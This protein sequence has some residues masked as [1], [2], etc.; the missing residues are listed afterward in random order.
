MTGKLPDNRSKDFL[1]E[2]GLLIKKVAPEQVSSTADFLQAINSCITEAEQKEAQNLII[3]APYDS[4]LFDRRLRL[5]IVKY[6]IPQMKH[7]GVKRVAFV[8]QKEN[9]LQ[10]KLVHQV[11]H[12]LEIGVFTTIPD[13]LGWIMNLTKP[14][15]N[16]IIDC[17][18][19][20]TDYCA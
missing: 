12:F 6:L 7:I 9:C 14:A 16:D 2:L 3:S 8:M 18:T 4:P 11:Y 1:S 19:K 13:A 15:N 17:S 5:W 10:R 20:Q